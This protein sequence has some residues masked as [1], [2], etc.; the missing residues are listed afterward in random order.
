MTND[1]EKSTNETTFKLWNKNFILLWQ[2]QLISSLGDIVYE[3]A[4]SFFILK[5]TGSTLMMSYLLAA[6]LLPRLL[7]SPIAGILADK[8][9]RKNIIIW[10]DL[11]RGV[12]ILGLGL[13]GIFGFISLW[14]LFATGFIIGVGGAFFNPAINSTIPDLTPKSRIMEANSAFSLIYGASSLLGYFLGGFFY[15]ILGAFVFFIINGSSY[16]ISAILE[17]FISIPANQDQVPSKSNILTD[18]KNL[19]KIITEIKG[20]RYLLVSN[21]F[22]SFFSILGVTLILPYFERKAEW[23]PSFYG[24]L[25]TCFTLGTILGLLALTKIKIHS[26]YHTSIYLGATISFSLLLFLTPFISNFWI[27]LL[28]VTLAGFTN[29]AIIVIEKVALQLSVLPENRSKVFGVWSTISSSLIPLGMISAGVLAN[30]YDIKILISASF[31]VIGI[32]GFVLIF[33]RSFK[34]FLNLEN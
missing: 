7:L 12:A 33:S 9:N 24:I 4:I 26:K 6:T 27:L 19:P 18:L 28:P 13:A 31:A 30:F 25:M 1:I 2:G 32:F 16:I 14:M 34:S 29:S 10:A 22:I 5:L 17:I 23:G 20:L 21:A 15:P 11:V 3:V 8:W